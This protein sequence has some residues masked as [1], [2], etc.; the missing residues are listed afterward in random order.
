MILNPQI[1]ANAQPKSLNDIKNT[2]SL[3][4]SLLSRKL[5]IDVSDLRSTN[6][7]VM[8]TCSPKTQQELI[9][10]DFPPLRSSHRCS[11]RS[12]FFFFSPLHRLQLFGPLN[13]TFQDYKRA[14]GKI[15]E[16]PRR[17]FDSVQFLPSDYKRTTPAEQ[18][19]GQIYQYL[20]M[21]S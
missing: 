11:R 17:W 8:L 9:S 10:F 18:V 1:A 19:E 21:R 14:A 3:H 15:N 2:S 13:I 16:R 5:S 7:G 4:S 12:F 20:H 6:P